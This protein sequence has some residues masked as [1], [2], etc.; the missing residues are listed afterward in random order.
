V[1]VLVPSQVGIALITGADGVMLLPQK[2]VTAGAVG[3]VFVAAGQLTVLPVLAGIV[4][5]GMSTVYT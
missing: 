1:Y 2:S 3:A 5:S 4:K